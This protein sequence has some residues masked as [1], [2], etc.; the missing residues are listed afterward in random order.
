VLDTT[1]WGA[2]A[3]S[4]N[5]V[6]AVGG[7]PGRPSGAPN[8][9]V[10]HYNGTQ[11]TQEVLPGTARNVALLKVWGTSAEDLY[12]VGERGTIWH[13]S[14]AGWEL[15]SALHSPALADGTL[16]SVH[17]CSATELY[18]AGGNTL[19]KSNGMAWEKLT[20]PALRVANGL[21]CGA[22]RLTVVGFSGL[23]V[24]RE[25][26][27]TLD[28]TRTQPFDNLH[29]AWTAPNGDIWVVGGDWVSSS[30]AG[31]VREGVI[32]RYGKGRVKAELAR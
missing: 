3:F 16:F 22:G 31:S 10:L 2:M 5:D 17:G 18:A 6:W 26:A 20:E 9:V 7:M 23:K 13:R 28:D 24:R 29:A 11:W 12:V 32:G 14:A 25:G 8:D 21:S 19:L 1:L 15:Q 30:T 27:A 4:A